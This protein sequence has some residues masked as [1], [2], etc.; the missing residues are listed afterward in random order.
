MKSNRAQEKVLNEASL[1]ER[2]GAP[3]GKRNC[4]ESAPVAIVGIGCR[5]PGDINNPDAFWEVLHNGV[6]T[7][8]KIP[9]DRFDADSLYHPEPGT[10]GR[11]VS[12][13]G[14]FIND[15]D[16][17]DA[18]YFGISPR[19]AQSMDPQQRFLLE[20]AVEAV[21]NAGIPFERISGSRTGV[22]IGIW[23]GDYESIMY[24]SRPQV[25]L[26]MTTGS[27]RYSAAGRLS[28]VLNLEGPSLTI[29]TACSSSLAAVHLACQSIRSNE[30]DM[31]MAGGVNLIMQPHISIAYSNSRMLSPQGRCRFGD[32][33][34]NGYVRSEGCGI[35]VLKKLSSAIA[36]GDRI[37]AT[38]LGSAV[39]HD[40]REGLFVAPNQN[41]QEKLLLA[42]CENA[43]IS[44]QDLAYIEAHGTGTAAGDPVELNGI[45][46]VLNQYGY[47]E[48]PCLVGSVKTNIGHTEAASGVAGLIKTALCLQ[49]GLVPKSLHFENPNPKIAWSK[50]LIQMQDQ[51]SVP[52]PE[53]P[54]ILAG[55]NSFGVSGTNVHVVLEKN[56]LLNEPRASSKR[57]G[58]KF[59]KD[60]ILPLSAH[61]EASL[62]TAVANWNSF[63]KKQENE[64]SDLYD[65][66]HTA[67]LRRTHYDHRFAAVG[68][69]REELADSL[70]AYK[71]NYGKSPEAIQPGQTA[72]KVAFVFSGQ[73]PQW[74]AMGRQLSEQEPVYRD[75]LAQISSMLK[76]YTGWDLMDELSKDESASR[77][78][79]TD[80]DQPAIFALQMGLGELWRH[81]GVEPDTVVGHSIGEVAAACFSGVLTLED[82]VRVVYHRSR[83]LEK[84]AGMGKMAAVGIPEADARKMIAPFEKRISLAAVNSASSVT[85]AGE[86]PAIREVMALFEKENI[87]CKMLRVN[88]PFHSA[89]VEPFKREMEES[90]QG[91]IPNPYRTPIVSTVSGKPAKSGDYGAA[92]WADNIR[93][94]VRFQSAVDEL[95]RSNHGIFLELS[96][97]PVLAM[98]IVQSLEAAGRRGEVLASL[99][100]GTDDL[101]KMLSSLKAYYETGKTVQWENVL[102]EKGNCVSLPSCPWHHER[103]WID[104]TPVDQSPSTVAV[105]AG[106][107][108]STPSL[109][110]YGIASSLKE[111]TYFFESDIGLARYPWLADHRVRGKIIFPAAGYLE[112]AAAAIHQTFPKA[113]MCLEKIEIKE[114]LFLEK[115]DQVKLQTAIFPLSTGKIALKISSSNIK[116][117]SS[118]QFRWREHLHAEM[119]MERLSLPEEMSWRDQLRG[120]GIAET[121]NQV[122]H[123]TAMGKIGLEYGKTFNGIASVDFNSAG[124][125]AYIEIP[126]ELSASLH[127]FILHPG[128]LDCGLQLL[129]AMADKKY[130]QSSV[131]W[132][133]VGLDSIN[134]HHSLG[135]IKQIEILAPTVREVSGSNVVSGDFFFV[136][137]N[138]E[139]FVEAKGVALRKLDRLAL[140]SEEILYTYHWQ[141]VSLYESL[142][143]GFLPAP[144]DIR[145]QIL[146]N[147]SSTKTDLE[148]SRIDEFLP[149][150]ENLS[151]HYIIAAFDKLGMNFNAGERFTF[152][153]MPVR[154]N[155]SARHGRLMHRLLSVLEEEGV[156]H[157]E[158]DQ[159]HVLKKPPV[160]EPKPIWQKLYEKYPDFKTE[161]AIFGRCGEN[162]SGVLRGDCDPLELIFPKGSTDEAETLYRDAY[163][164]KESNRRIMQAVKLILESLPDGRKLRILEIGAGTGGLTGHILP[165]LPSDRSSYTFTDIGSLFINQ[166]RQKYREYPFVEY[167]TLD[168][169]KD[170]GPQGFPSHGFDLV[171][172]ANCL[173]ATKFMTKTLSNVLGL[174]A[175]EGTMLLIEG[176]RSQRWIDLVF[177]LTDGWWRFEDVELRPEHPLMSSKTWRNL[178]EETGFSESA[179]VGDTEETGRAIFQQSVVI[180]RGPENTAALNTQ[181]GKRDV[182]GTG[183]LIFSEGGE[184]A[185]ILCEKITRLGDQY[186]LVS[187]GEAFEN[188]Q[189]NI[190][191]IEPG[192]KSHFE[193]VTNGF[194][195]LQD[196]LFKKII[197]LWPMEYSAQAS[198]SP[199][200][201]LQDPSGICIDAL[202]VVQRLVEASSL[203]IDKMF[204]VSANSQPTGKEGSATSPTTAALIGLGK[205]V[206]LEHPELHLHMVDLDSAKAAESAE[207]LWLELMAESNEDQVV[208]RGGSR[209]LPRMIPYSQKAFRDPEWLPVPENAPFCLTHGGKRTLSALNL[210]EQK[211]PSG[212]VES[213]VQIRV[214]A[215]GMNFKDLLVA[216]KM[217]DSDGTLGLECA[218]VVTG[219]GANVSEFEIGDEVIAAGSGAYATFFTTHADLVVKKPASLTFEEAAT[220]PIAFLTA[221][222][223]LNRLAGLRAGEKVLIHAASGGVGLA[224]VQM[225]KNIGAEIFGTAGNPAKRAFLKKCGVDHVL[226]S[227]STDFAPAIME[228][229]QGKGVDVVLNSLTGEFIQPSFSVLRP[230]GRFMEIGKAGIWS[231]QEAAAHR[232]DVQYEIFDL[233]SIM[234]NKPE[235]IKPAFKLLADA[236]RQGELKSLPLH[237]ATMEEVIGAFRY[238]Q[239]AKHI[240]KIV[241]N[242]PEWG[243]A[244]PIDSQN[245]FSGAKAYLISGGFG[246]LGIHT[247]KWLFDRGARHLVLTG[248]K[249]PKEAAAKIISEMETAGARIYRIFGDVSKK[250]DVASLFDQIQSQC[251]PLAGVFHLAG[252]LDD[253]ALIR[254]NRER[255]EKVLAP[256]A[257]G[258]FNLHKATLDIPL[259]C[260]VLFSSWASF[261]GSPGQANHSAANACMDALAWLRKAKGLPGLSINWGAWAEIGA[262]AEGDRKE[263][264]ANRGIGS[265]SPEEGVAI[266]GRLMSQGSAQVAVFPFD[267]EKW[268]KFDAAFPNAKRF[269]WITCDSEENDSSLAAPQEAHH[270]ESIMVLLKAVETENEKKSMVERFLKEQISQTLGLAVSAVGAGKEFRAYG[271]DSLTAL[272]YR[273]R[274]ESGLGLSLPVTLVWNYPTVSK[275]A[276]HLLDKLDLAEGMSDSNA[277]DVDAPASESTK[278]ESN[279]AELDDLLK[280]IDSLS[281]DEIRKILDEDL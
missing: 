216:L 166:A 162:L 75:M 220:I 8:S 193:K 102:T 63:L 29:D 204:W 254:M 48:N 246:G 273:N 130:G 207:N 276:S 272:E 140:K 163:F 38:I 169:E 115:D 136:D 5:F 267:L 206:R 228:M 84:T 59:P 234:I 15:V 69:S 259:D 103:F 149:F 26:Y 105:L 134:I 191:T 60:L 279:E 154:L 139:S 243:P 209:W 35:V 58:D 45:V 170:P 132:L 144:N 120:T 159:W 129:V 74:F 198:D 274:L 61:S 143:S 107:A 235:S 127:E 251:P 173:H 100:R 16:K 145:S 87:F 108:Y 168:I 96:P 101:K 110:G 114:A 97:H 42:A 244:N 205:V 79:Q 83:I 119:D 200:G 142:S 150:M 233:Y 195:S 261:L 106:P 126:E 2:S 30:S 46:S 215:T 65:I 156:V 27:G 268:R 131:T 33:S 85:L 277:E 17:F 73:G 186:I 147:E 197:Y 123:Y 24:A 109:L 151:L 153:E 196:V 260:F 44:A 226:D 124:G 256:K 34:A 241:V 278:K 160:P 164:S 203:K 262:A 77:I 249:P 211:P 176:S 41:A 280:E 13:E 175:P 18:G 174:L 67:A 225:A 178:L 270:S 125:R 99:Q 81:W 188:V 76:K 179:T 177:G 269:E 104:K 210:I 31:A 128:I 181:P 72:P 88:Y 23:N 112:M 152:D 208:F 223:T 242:Q 271:M 86:A 121:S 133:P 52:F 71:E 227:R 219:V 80:F 56:P 172:A 78:G 157:R 238:M 158:E 53:V 275:L 20:V 212:P 138:G 213:D 236:F 217:I 232:D 64:S 194:N 252:A 43:G 47:R 239:Q 199:E 263:R 93:N 118:E 141:S 3:T 54:R 185:D 12:K 266:L 39:N 240:G 255:F 182:P 146:A 192:Q 40:G 113:G 32:Q 137:E 117:E 28:Y 171:V 202:N 122:E 7:I 230:G 25:D 214:R 95:I 89:A 222:F 189:E 6:D 14:G 66:C 55:V 10:P 116:K 248:R 135:K 180:G 237:M 50:K 37:Y 218:G 201:I 167:K 98:S 155:V 245:A 229:T 281:D 91:I 265:F 57:S 51:D 92:Y 21:E 165:M 264:L 231:P 19:E 36:D 49:R 161:L 221:H 187:R 148:Q 247:A 82:A 258:A 68:K 250:G 90:V 62:K 253:G 4:T 70:S 184:L 94:A 22:F 224:A 111:K 257:L 183:W 11:I 1:S 190:F 9:S